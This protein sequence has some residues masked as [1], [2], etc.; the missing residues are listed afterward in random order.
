[1]VYYIVLLLIYFLVSINELA[2]PIASRK[3]SVYCFLLLLPMWA[4]V[5][6]RAETIGCDTARYAFNYQ[7]AQSI[8]SLAAQMA[9]SGMEKGYVLIRALFILS[10]LSFYTFQIAITTYIYISL[11]RFFVRYSSNIAMSCL[12]LLLTMRF[13]S[14][15]N[16]T[17]MWLAIATVLFSLPY[18]LNRKFLKFLLIVAIAFFFHK[19]ALLFVIMYPLCHL[20]YNRLL[21]AF[22]IL[23]AVIITYS[24]VQFFGWFTETTGIYE[25]YIDN[26]QFSE[27]RSRLAAFLNLAESVALFVFFLTA[28]AFKQS[29]YS[30]ISDSMSISYGHFQK[31]SFL[32]FLGF[33]VIGL[34]N[35]MMGRVSS[36]FSIVLLNLIPYSISR[37]RVDN[38]LI[39]YFVVILLFTIEFAVKIIYRPYWYDVTPYEW[40]FMSVK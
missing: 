10:N 19:S 17:R 22:I 8:N 15:M 30:D 37:V 31:L 4:L 32:L 12:L 7:S 3:R 6:F 36:Y 33:S 13:F 2:T 5:A 14:S 38:R 28:N 23:G 39:V 18:L 24:G 29:Q 25:D 21:A 35:N 20:K 34:S 27:D 16:Q 11:H 1:M 26:I 9:S 40:F